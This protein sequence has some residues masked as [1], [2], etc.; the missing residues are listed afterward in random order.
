MHPKKDHVICFRATTFI[1]TCERNYIIFKIK[2][3][4]ENSL[5]SC[6]HLLQKFLQQNSATHP[7]IALNFVLLKS[8]LPY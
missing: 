5:L 2:L 3:I 6:L 7:V 8:L 4:F 1:Y